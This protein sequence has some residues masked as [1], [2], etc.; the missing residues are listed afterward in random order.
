MYPN[1]IQPKDV[2]LRFHVFRLRDSGFRDQDPGFGASGLRGRRDQDLG[3]RASR[4][5]GLGF[6]V[7]GFKG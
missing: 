5:K 2:K 1:G 7:Q 3:F 4:A 6:R